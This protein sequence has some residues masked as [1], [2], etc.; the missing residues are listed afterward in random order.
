MCNLAFYSD[1]IVPPNAAVDRRL[2]AMMT[3]RGVG[4]HIGYIPSGPDP[5]RRFFRERRAYYARYGLDLDLCFDLDEPP[6]AAAIDK[7]FSCDAIHLSGG[8]TAGF[9]KRLGASG[10][11]A[12]LAAWARRGGILIGTSAG[13]I[14]MTPT[15]ASD[16]L[17]SGAAPEEVEGGA[18]LDLV[19]FEF[20]PH[21]GGKPAYLPELLRYSRLTSRPIVACRDGDGLVV[22]EGRVECIGD[23]VWIMDGAARAPGD[24]QLAGLAITRIV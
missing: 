23:P 18:A 5:G 9:L 16:A 14:L 22:T 24:I 3:V 20:F 11:H 7:L 8:H 13:A 10:M 1:Q 2:L 15:I 6:D 17:F 4:S 21:L 19:P 12:R